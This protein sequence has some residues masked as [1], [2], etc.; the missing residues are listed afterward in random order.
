MTKITEKPFHRQIISYDLQSAV[1]IAL[2]RRKK[3]FQEGG[4]GHRD[5]VPANYM[6]CSIEIG[7]AEPPCCGFEFICKALN[8]GDTSDYFSAQNADYNCTTQEAYLTSPT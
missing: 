8:C 2:R 4:V 1:Q 3:P 5:T 7:A 6:V